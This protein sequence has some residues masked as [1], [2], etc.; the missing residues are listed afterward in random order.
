MK[1]APVDEWET[2]GRA[3]DAH[4]LRARPVVPVATLPRQVETAPLLVRTPAEIAALTPEKPQFIAPYVA[5]GSL[6]EITGYAKKGKT[7]LLAYIV[8]CIVHG[9]EC[10][11]QPTVETGVFW[12]TEERLPTFRATLNRSGLLAAPRLHVV[13]KWDVPASTSWPAVIAAAIPLCH[14]LSCGVLVVDTLPAWAGL[15]GDKENNAGDALAA[16]EPLQRAAAAGV[17]VII[18]RHDR[19]GGGAVGESGRGSSAFA[20]AMDTLL[21][22][23]LQEGQGHPT[24]RVLKAVSRFD[25]VPPSLLVERAE[26]NAYSSCP[27][28][29]KFNKNFYRPLGAPGDLAVK[30]TENAIVE[31][32]SDWMTSNDLVSAL[33]SYG[34]GTVANLLKDLH[35]A[36]LDRS[37]GGVKNNP[38]LYRRRS[39]VDVSYST[40]IPRVGED[41]HSSEEAVDGEF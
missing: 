41:K 9:V 12:L 31:M 33:P 18:V 38:Y 27:T 8:G 1:E 26:P 34:K 25:E 16:V 35:P 6:L 5:S 3:V 30:A 29:L 21:S 14:S 7:S 15:T 40:P 19:K 39:G 13:S 23:T 22:L 24:Q 36:R 32:A 17:A 20:G 10:L 4:A 2:F 11:D 28:G 37:G